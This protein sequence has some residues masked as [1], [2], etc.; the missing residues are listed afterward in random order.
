M[1]AREILPKK[2]EEQVTETN[3]STSAIPGRSFT[4]DKSKRA[5]AKWNVENILRGGKPDK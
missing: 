5:K 3:G 2:A 4:P 1:R